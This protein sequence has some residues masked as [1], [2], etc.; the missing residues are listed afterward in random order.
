[1]NRKRNGFK[2]IM[3]AVLLLSLAG[4]LYQGYRGVLDSLTIIYS[5]SANS[6]PTYFD[7]H[8]I[9]EAHETSKGAGVKVGILDWGFGYSQHPGLYA[10]GMDF[11]NNSSNYNEKSEH[12]YWMAGVL[13]EIAPECAIYAIGAYIPDNEKAWTDALAEAVDWAIENDMD[14]LTLSQQEIS[15]EY[16]PKIDRAAEKAIAQNIVISFIHYD[17]PD[18]ILPYGLD[19]YC[20]EYSREPD[21]NILHYDYNLFF[22]SRYKE[23]EKGKLDES[24]L[25]YSM[26]STAPVTAGFTAI[27]KSI[28]SRLTPADCKNLLIQSSYRLE[29][30]GTMNEHVI[31]IGAAVKLLKDTHPL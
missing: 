14:I 22:L 6:R 20:G 2:V 17:H 15:E 23:Y 21:V 26:S 25:Y 8:N 16:R 12:G 30:E 3:T 18:N 4:N 19:G 10:G 24:G 11:T 29:F 28:D 13:K 5:P 9:H 7:I 31:D 27:L 1:M